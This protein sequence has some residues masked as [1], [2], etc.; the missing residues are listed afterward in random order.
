[1]RILGIVCSPRKEGNTE[2][3]VKEALEAAC[4]AGSQTEL[5]LVAD[6]DI[7]PCDGCGACQK[8][9]ICK[10]WSMTA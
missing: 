4:E 5:F 8:D 7:R 10:L 6:K 2:V 9:G 3:L 1:M